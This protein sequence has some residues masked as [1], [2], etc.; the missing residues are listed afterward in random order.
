MNQ[1]E[2]AKEK[3]QYVHLEYPFDRPGPRQDNKGTK[4]ENASYDKMRE[5]R[6][7]TPSIEHLRKIEWSSI[8]AVKHSQHGNNGVILVETL[9]GSFVLKGSNEPALELFYSVFLRSFHQSTPK[10]RILAYNDEEFKV[11]IESLE[12]ATFK[13]PG[14]YRVIQARLNKPFI[15]L[16]QYV[17]G[18]HL[19]SMSS[20]RADRALNPRHPNC[21]RRLITIGL[22]TAIDVFLNNPDRFPLTAIWP[23]VKGNTTNVLFKLE[24][25]HFTTN[26]QMFDP[27]DTKLQF[28]SVFAFDSCPGTTRNINL[29]TAGNILE[30]Q[31][32]FNALLDQVF[33]QIR[34]I[35]LAHDSVLDVSV[36][37]RIGLV[38]SISKLIEQETGYDIEPIGEFQLLIGLALG[39]SNIY[40]F[41][42]DRVTILRD[43]I[44]EVVKA[45]FKDIWKNNAS[46]IDVEFLQDSV[47][48]IRRTLMKF[49]D[50]VSWV[51]AITLNQ[52]TFKFDLRVNDLFEEIEERRIKEQ[53]EKM[54]KEEK[55]KDLKT[56]Q[57]LRQLKPWEFGDEELLRQ[58]ESVFHLSYDIVREETN[59]KAENERLRLE[60][61]KRKQRLAAEYEEKRMQQEAES[62]RIQ[63][64][65]EEELRKSK[66]KEEAQKMGV[67]TNSQVSEADSKKKKGGILGFFSKKKK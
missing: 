30:Y 27:N 13:D 23:S 38:S 29:I 50:V 49:D 37:H 43:Q 24:C 65:A 26:Q 39:F 56:Q 31:K 34:E 62:L 66:A 18:I 58:L 61:I 63:Q 41:G 36:Q 3:I 55:D 52:F 67:T 60:E 57:M 1:R 7:P 48:A 46:L 6:H 5:F 2:K 40:H 19:T 64:E 42:L 59:Q 22:L 53:I 33:N 54:E 25:D 4:I 11:M 35:M 51:K 20:K 10:M 17:P 21:R 32:R 16:M 47:Y 28:E 14:L 15:L 12:R 8:T 9:K 44:K 45:D